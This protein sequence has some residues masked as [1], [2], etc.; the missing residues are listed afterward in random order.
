MTD[1]T[2][3]QSRLKEKLWPVVVFLGAVLF[4]VNFFQIW[5]QSEWENPI[6]I[7]STPI[8]LI[9]FF[10]S[11]AILISGFA[12]IIRGSNP[13]K[14]SFNYQFVISILTFFVILVFFLS[15]VKNRTVIVQMTGLATS[16]LLSLF[17]AGYVRK[18]KIAW[19]L[20][21]IF[22]VILPI[23]IYGYTWT[24]N[25]EIIFYSILMLM[26]VS[27]IASFFK[28]VDFLTASEEQKNI[29]RNILIGACLLFGISFAAT[30]YIIVSIFAH[31]GV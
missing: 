13:I 8:N 23:I 17:F 15:W 28:L 7:I 25:Y 30:V 14:W 11:V 19:Y 21:Y 31:W 18:I 27:G 10:T 16:T 6:H 3:G 9:L 4:F 20:W 24:T 26:I 1:L 12:F 5:S 2:V 29:E 22:G